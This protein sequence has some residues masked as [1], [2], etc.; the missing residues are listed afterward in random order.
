MIT[1]LQ[2]LQGDSMIEK[3]VEY[4]HWSIEGLIDL[5][6]PVEEEKFNQELD[7]LFVN[8][9]NCPTSSIRSLVEHIMMGLYFS[10]CIMM[11]MPN[12]P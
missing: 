9:T 6:L 10:S 11:E 4:T 12:I 8:D 1:T 3:I 7:E 2:I 5:L